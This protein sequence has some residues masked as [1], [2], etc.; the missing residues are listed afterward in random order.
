MSANDL[1]R[2]D[3]FR[4]GLVGTAGVAAG[5]LLDGQPAAAYNTTAIDHP[6]FYPPATA[7]TVRSTC[8]VCFWKC[9][10][11]VELGE[12]GELLNISPVDGHPLSRGKLC[13]RGVGGIGFYEDDDRLTKPQIRVGERGEAVYRNTSWDEA[14][15]EIGKRLREIIDADG[16]GAV[17]FLTHGAAEAHFEHLAAAIGTAHHAHPAYDQCKAP[18][19]VGYQLTFGHAMHSPEPVDIENTDCLVLIGSH[20]GENMHNLQ[21]QELVTAGT[22]GANLIVV[23]PRRSTAAL[24]ADIWLQ[25]KPGT[26]I[27]LLLAWTHI[28]IRDGLYD[29]DFVNEFTSGFDLLSEHVARTT[30]EWAAVET[31]LT[32]KEIEASARMIGDAGSHMAL[33]PGRHV[34]WYGNDTQRARAMAILVA[35]TGAWGSRGGYYL[36]QKAH[37]PTLEEVYPDM[38]EFPPLADRRDPGYPFAVGVNVNGIRQATIDG[39]I[40]A[41]VVVGTNL[42]TTLPAQQETVEALKKLEFLAVVDV[43]PTEITTYADVLLPAASY[44]ERWD[45]LTVTQSRDPFVAVVQKAVE[46]IGESRGEAQIAR[47][48]GAELGLQDY[49]PWGSVEEL[50]EAVITKMNE[51]YPEQGTVDWTQL[52]KEGFVV[53]NEGRPIYR[54]GHGLGTDG[55]GRAGAE[56]TFPPFKGDDGDGLVHLYSPDLEAVWR[57]KVAAG[58][59]PTGYEP[60]PTYYPPVSA[61]PGHVRLLYGRSPVHTFGRTQNTP[62][63]FGRQEDNAVWISPSAAAAFGV[64]EGD[65]VDLVNQDGA[66]QGPVRMLVTDR[67]SDDAVYTTHGFGHNSRQLTRAYKRGIDDSALM[68]K[69]AVDPLSGGTG[70]RVNFV[71]VV[72][73]NSA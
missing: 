53:L 63:L 47:D 3:L 70:M 17:A 33:H 51:M 15:T 29:S 72:K 18:R 60:L 49:W 23:D 21:V 20:L 31:G 30:P 36:P 61:P 65:Q 55:R 10:I 40:K 6:H 35:I 59:D 45:N 67:M 68:T 38:P 16:P 50:D 56:L 19:E 48:I 44:L 71:R 26:D 43:L 27:A 22:G 34:V 14:N 11:D 25:I 57:E 46:P 24:R 37:L 28:L 42:I 52:T 12:E 58:D 54:E 9:G 69:Y 73:H 8:G 4:Y 62:V 5:I 66:R 2:R 64:K 7:S 32:V 39:S 41:W 13:P 1:T